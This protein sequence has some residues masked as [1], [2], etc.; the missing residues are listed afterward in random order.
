M[1]A[2][3]GYS[4]IFRPLPASPSLAIPW[5]FVGQNV[6]D[7]L[8]GSTSWAS[9]AS[10]QTARRGEKQVSSKTTQA[11]CLATA[12]AFCRSAFAASK[13]SCISLQG[14]KQKKHNN[15]DCQE[16]ARQTLHIIIKSYR[17]AWLI[18][19][20]MLIHG[21]CLSSLDFGRSFMLLASGSWA[22]SMWIRSA[23][24]WFSR[25]QRG[26]VCWDLP[27]TSCKRPGNASARMLKQGLETAKGKVPRYMSLRIPLW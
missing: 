5:R 20:S 16:N 13:S 6:M 23:R 24:S 7:S 26:K 21:S 18:G 1:H 8:G 25:A 19:L 11:P 10:L 22:P 14:E 4:I 9:N 3:C 2:A 27:G 12:F 15:Q 17:F